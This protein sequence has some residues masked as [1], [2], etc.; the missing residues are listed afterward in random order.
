MVIDIFDRN[1][2]S[3]KVDENQIFIIED[4]YNKATYLLNT[5]GNWTR[6]F[7]STYPTPTQKNRE[8]EFKLAVIN[9]A[10]RG[11][12]SIEW[13]EKITIDFYVATTPHN[14]KV[15]STS[16]FD[17]SKISKANTISAMLEMS[18]DYKPTEKD[19]EG[20]IMILTNTFED[21][22]ASNIH[23]IDQTD[24]VLFDGN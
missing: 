18:E 24:N 22:D 13:V 8:K 10:K 17:L 12:E 20:V 6:E 9:A 4:H 2:I 15:V 23:I 3:Y 14:S 7:V 16:S 1:S 5:S 21:L 19:I 11:L